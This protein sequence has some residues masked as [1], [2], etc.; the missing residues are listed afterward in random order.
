MELININGPNVSVDEFNEWIHALR[1]GK[2]IQ[3]RQTLETVDHKFC[4]LGVACMVYIDA[5]NREMD[6]A[7]GDTLYGAV[8]DFDTQPAAPKWLALINDHFMSKAGRMLTDLNDDGLT[9]DG[10]F[11]LGAFTFDEIADLLELVYIHKILD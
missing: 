9:E 5:H 3:G 4:C 11:I 10:E 1:S 8:I 2:Y 6:K 7:K